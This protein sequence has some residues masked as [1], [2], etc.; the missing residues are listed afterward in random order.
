MKG[1]C[2]KSNKMIM[3]EKNG[4]CPYCEKM[5]TDTDD[6]V[7][8]P[9]CGTP[10]H[11]ECFVQHGECANVSKHAE[12]FVFKSESK[13]GD[14]S[15]KTEPSRNEPVICPQCGTEISPTTLVCPGCG[16]RFGVM[17]N[18]GGFAY[19]TDFFMKG[20][21]A[22]ADEDLG[23]FTVKDA[24]MY[25]QSKASDYIKKFSKQKK[26]GKSTGWNWAAFLFTPLW[27]FYR[28]LYK[29]G[30][31]FVAVFVA[32]SLFTAVPASKDYNKAMETIEKYVTVYEDSSY[33]DL[34]KQIASLSPEQMNEVTAAML[35]YFK[36]TFIQL[37]IQIIPSAV[38]ALFADKLYKNK[39]ARDIE[40]MREFSQ[41]QK[42]FEMLMLRKGGT[43]IVGMFAGYAVWFL[44]SNIISLL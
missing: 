33:E 19:N 8:C 27:F 7:Y 38:A 24:A 31:C 2:G 39:I 44:L 4:S 21:T 5:F 40:S 11:R 41:N 18:M 28:K 6:T 32:I 30:L 20:V 25:T 23:G 22:D 34:S 1:N 37:A 14:N 3:I 16:M 35:G 15:E 43:S 42:T 29:A 9:E 36:W 10:H 26:T 17:P 12:G 13:T